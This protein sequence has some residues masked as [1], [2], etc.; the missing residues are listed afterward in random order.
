MAAQPR[1]R[2]NSLKDEFKLLILFVALLAGYGACASFQLWRAG[3]YQ[4]DLN[5]YHDWAFYA[6]MYGFMIFVTCLATIAIALRLRR[7]LKAL[8]PADMFSSR[9]PTALS[10]GERAPSTA[11]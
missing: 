9:R 5:H 6:V 1:P 4:Y 8:L 7:K 10:L 2:T 11:K 3:K